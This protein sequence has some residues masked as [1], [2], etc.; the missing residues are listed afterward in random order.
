MNESQD[1]ESSCKKY[2]N[3]TRPE[4]ELIVEKCI[5]L[6]NDGKRDYLISAKEN[7]NFQLQYGIPDIWKIVVLISAKYFCY[8]ADDYKLT[9]NGK[10]KERVYIFKIPYVL[11][12]KSSD[13]YFKL[14]LRKKMNSEDVFVL[15]IHRPK[16][17]LNLLW[18]K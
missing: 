10:K 1:D 16:K 4:I 17:T 9:K 12:D 14:K 11:E 7:F 2:I 5:S 13:I 15:S 3:N 6:I 18:N 8:S